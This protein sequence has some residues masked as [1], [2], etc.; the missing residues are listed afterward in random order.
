MSPANIVHKFCTYVTQRSQSKFTVAF[1]AN[2]LKREETQS[3]WSNIDRHSSAVAQPPFADK[4]CPTVCFA[5]VGRHSGDPAVA[6]SPTETTANDTS[7]LAASSEYRT[8]TGRKRRNE[9]VCVRQSNAAS[10]IT[11]RK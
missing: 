2:Q 7:A 1:A 8:T 5:V 3:R 4:F 6:P 11:K 9:F 10:F